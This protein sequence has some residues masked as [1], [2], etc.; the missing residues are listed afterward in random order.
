MGMS[1]NPTPPRVAPRAIA[2]D[3]KAAGRR[4][5]PLTSSATHALWVLAVVAVVFL[6]RESGGLLIPIVI[7]ILISYA[8]EPAVA[9]LQRRG[10]QR[11]L[12]AGLVV[13]AILGLGGWS[14]LG[15]RHEVNLAFEAL[16]DA[17]RQTRDMIWSQVQSGPGQQVK[18]AVD[19]LQQPP[20]SV[21]GGQK[22]VPANGQ[23]PVASNEGLFS[24]WIQLGIG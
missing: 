6:L 22:A 21:P 16:P 24:E 11:P 17:A 23:G 8:L 19:E 4:R 7:A 12:G 5:R 15:L 3:A 1:A 10:V 20:D 18:E 2:P 13:V 14:A 9:W